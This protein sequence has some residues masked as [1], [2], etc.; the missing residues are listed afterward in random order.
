MAT[1]LYKGF[2]VQN[3][4]R[5][6]RNTQNPMGSVSVRFQFCFSLRNKVTGHDQSIEPVVQLV[7]GITDFTELRGEGG[8]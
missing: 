3:S 8:G 1:I 7:S 5:S 2:D 4:F 6:F